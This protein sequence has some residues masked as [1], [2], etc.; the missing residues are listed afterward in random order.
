MKTTLVMNFK[1][2]NGKINAI[3][4]TSP[5]ADLTEAEVKEVANMLVA[6]NIFHVGSSHLEALDRAFIR[7][8]EE[9]ALP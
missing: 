6:K 7:T 8:V 4:I 9:T 3:S 1:L 5:R 2:D